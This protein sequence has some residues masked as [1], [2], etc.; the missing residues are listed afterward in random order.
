MKKLVLGTLM[1]TVAI[2]LSSCIQ[3]ESTTTNPGHEVTINTPTSTKTPEYIAF[4]TAYYHAADQQPSWSLKQILSHLEKPAR[5]FLISLGYS[6]QELSNM[7]T[8]LMIE[9]A[10]HQYADF[11]Y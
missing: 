4:Q 1:G 11:K 6:N 10:F 9:R 7:G 2:L 5:D 3:D 8:E